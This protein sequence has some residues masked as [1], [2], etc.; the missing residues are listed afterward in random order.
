VRPLPA[1]RRA[2]KSPAT[3][4][5]RVLRPGASRNCWIGHSPD[6]FDMR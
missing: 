3:E 5:E 2:P 4:P 1:K 6:V